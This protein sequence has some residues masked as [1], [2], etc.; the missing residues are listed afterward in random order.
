M[1]Y[2]VMA[3]FVMAYVVM[4]YTARAYTVMAVISCYSH[5]HVRSWADR[6]GPVHHAV[7]ARGI[8]QA[9]AR[10]PF[11]RGHNYLDHNHLGR[12]YLGHDY[13]GHDYIGHN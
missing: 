2:I 9:A 3:Y 6:D 13:M 1:T 12:N 7:S 5:S 11:L 4:A 8:A 10:T